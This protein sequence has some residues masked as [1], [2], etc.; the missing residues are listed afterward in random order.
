MSLP[1]PPSLAVPFAVDATAPYIRVVPIDSQIGIE[2]GAASWRTG[3]V[4]LNMTLRTAGGVAPFGSD[5]NGVMNYISANIAWAAAGCGF[6]FN[7]DVVDNWT[8]YPEGAVIRDASDP[9]KFLYNILADNPN[10]PG[11]DL[12]GWVSFNPLSTPTDQQI[13]L[14][15]AGTTNNLAV[16]RNVGFLDI[17]TTAGNVTLTGITAGSDGQILVVTNVGAN[18]LT[19]AALNTGSSSANRFRMPSDLSFVLND[20]M[21]LRYSSQVG[22]WARM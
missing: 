14:P 1:Y 13:E 21:S 7:Q 18:L 5:M 11:I 10:N 3:F 16:G 8:G 15:A 9:S 2:N 22:K 12:T 6:V 20:G 19:L 17:D 4:P